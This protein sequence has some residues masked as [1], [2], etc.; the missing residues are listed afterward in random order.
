[1]HSFPPELVERT[2]VFAVYPFGLDPHGFEDRKH[3]L[4]RVCKA[5]RSVI[6]SGPIFWSCV[7]IDTIT[8]LSSVSFSL[9]R[10]GVLPVHVYIDLFGFRA[11]LHGTRPRAVRPLRVLDAMLGVLLPYMPRCCRISIHT[12]DTSASLAVKNRLPMLLSHGLLRLDL[13]LSPV[14]WLDVQSTFTP[15][16]TIQHLRV[17]YHALLLPFLSGRC[18]LL[19]LDL[20]HVHDTSWSQLLLVLETSS[21]LSRLILSDV[22]C[23]SFYSTTLFAQARACTLPSL[24]TLSLRLEDV[25]QVR[26]L[27]MLDTP[28]LQVFDCDVLSG[29]VEAFIDIC[30]DGF[31]NTARVFICLHDIWARCLPRLLLALPHGLTL[32]GLGSSSFT[33]STLHPSSKTYFHQQDTCIA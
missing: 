5:W 20:R 3:I 33:A 31:V 10:S 16:P 11:V 12:H 19:S 29:A 6:F 24:T 18:N 7:L 4:V 32:L 17:S 26:L 2:L 21:Y 27:S 22:S 13:D 9:S 1:M 14:D 8:P 30:L 15:V 23:S 25:A 28:S